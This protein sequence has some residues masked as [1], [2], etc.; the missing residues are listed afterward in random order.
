[1]ACNEDSVWI[2][3]Y[4][5]LMWKVDFVYSERIPGYIRGFK[6][7]FWQLSE[8]HRGIPGKPGRVVTLIPGNADD[9]VWGVAYCLGGSPA[10]V[11]DVIRKLDHREKGGYD[12][13]FVDFHYRDGQ[14]VIKDVT[15]YI[16]SHDNPLYSPH[17]GDDLEL[18]RHILNSHG[19]SGSNLE[20]VLKLADAIRDLYPDE[21]H[22]LD[23]HVMQLEEN[24][25]SL[26]KHGCD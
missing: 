3:A 20:Y 23:D 9:M 2:F 26:M 10:E 12:R 8:D 24:L 15:I 1:M 14:T 17:E 22:H 19:P 13:V 4:G 7:R 5:S 21:E 11:Q 6:R 18:A 25:K 16:A